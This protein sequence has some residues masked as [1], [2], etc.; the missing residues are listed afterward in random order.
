MKR[1]QFGYICNNVP[2]EILESFNIQPKRL[3]GLN[4]DFVIAEKYLPAFSCSFIKSLFEEVLTRDDIDGIVTS[5]SCDA[6]LTLS[7]LINMEKGNKYF[8]N[9]L[10]PISTFAKE[11][12]KFYI[13]ELK[14]FSK[15]LQKYTNTNFSLEHLKDVMKHYYHLHKNIKSIMTAFPTK[16]QEKCKY[17]HF[18]ELLQQGYNIS[19]K[20]FA[21]SI[22]DFQKALNNEPLLNKDSY[23]NNVFL[24][25]NIYYNKKLLEIIEES[26][27]RITGDL[28]CFSGRTYKRTTDIEVGKIDKYTEDELY[29]LLA[30]KYIKS[31]PC[32]SRNIKTHNQSW[33]TMILKEIEESK[34]KSVIFLN[35]KYCDPNALQFYNIKKL[36]KDKNIPSL[37][38]EYDY[39]TNNI[40]QLITRIEAFSE[41][42]V[43]AIG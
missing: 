20:E 11:G 36:L 15:K 32:Y 41:S 12:T 18:L 29:D 43:G 1:I 16:I 27:F 22:G 7:D 14:R 25:G 10:T 26:G 39:Q 3:F 34:A 17:S 31:Y 6:I 9:F 40:Q 28:L 4:E 42:I 38:L 35:I 37:F 33:D 2:I 13:D 24:L 30:S 23:S 8:H 5:I 19:I 21:D